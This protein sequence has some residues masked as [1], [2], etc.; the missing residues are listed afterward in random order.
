MKRRLIAILCVIALLSGFTATA[1]G[2]AFSDVPSDSWAKDSIAGV[3][4]LGVMGGYGSGIF[5]Y[6][7]AITRA[8]FAVMLPRLFHWELIS[9]DTPTFKDNADKSAWY[10]DDVETLVI[11]GAVTAEN[12][13]FRPSAPITREEMAVMLVRALGYSTLSDSLK[14]PKTP[15]T[16]VSS[17]LA[18]IAMA[19]DFGIISGT[20]PTTFAPGSTAKREEAA[21]MMIR[22]YNR[23]YSKLGW[24]HAFYAISSYNQRALIPDFNA[25]SFG[26]SKLEIDNTGQPMLNTTTSNGNSYSIPSG[27]QEVVQLAKNNGVADNL[28]VYLT[29]SKTITMPDGTSTD[30]CSVILIN[31]GN[32]TKAIA[33]IVTELQRENNY[34][35]VTIDFEEMRGAQLKNG[36]NLFLQELQS[37]TSALGLSLYV[38]VSPVTSD[39]IYHDGYDYRT[40]GDC[41]DK[42]ILMAHDYAAKSLTASEMN[43]GYTQTPVTPI[44]E[45]Y[46]ALRA[47]TD[48]L[49][50]V[51]DKSKI[52]LAISFSSIQWQLQNNKV[53]KASAFQPN[54]AS[55]YNR[56]IDPATEL[57]Y[58][59]KYQNPYIK[60]HNA[61]DDTDNIGWY[62]DTRSV[63]AKMDL[64][65]MF[66]ITGISIWRLGLIPAYSDTA[67]RQIYYD[68]PAWLA[69]R[70]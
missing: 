62:E 15:F 37:Q 30:P 9:P 21:A 22:L 13:L 61:T 38:C 6:G 34:S 17:N 32:R 39:G 44:Y 42:V 3:E 53:I 51:Q 12:A 49:T 23:F 58:S 64:A 54:P 20:T 68:I 33:Q 10:Y 40:I 59:V 56:L 60:Y 2:T 24:S 67:D 1:E 36:F 69:N 29:A 16:D 47:I 66:G 26:W 43:A 45:I 41:A 65:R 46:T 55:I 35:G 27:Y 14:N 7:N 52:A 28:N 63:E 8:E 70:K 18:Y 25:I 31:P 57:N 11:K 4:A 5:G 48:S 50:G 19:Y